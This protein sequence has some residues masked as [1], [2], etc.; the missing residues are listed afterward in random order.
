[1]EKALIVIDFQKEWIDGNSEE[2]VGKIDEVIERVNNL[3]NYSRENNYKIIF[4][5]HLEKDSEDAWSEGSEGVK[6]IENLNRRDSD[7]IVVK[8]KINPFYETNLDNE[9]GDVDEILVCGIL[10]NLCVRMFIEE[11][12]DRDF[13]IRVIKDCCVAYDSEIQEF[14]FKDLKQTREE[15]EFLN[16]ENLE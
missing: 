1:M 10:T 7:I 14:T 12:Y 16:L 9:L 6:L 11:A 8:N 15:I 2:Y 13:R 5:K 3:I 4:T